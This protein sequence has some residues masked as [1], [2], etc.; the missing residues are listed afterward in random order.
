MKDETRQALIDLL[1]EKNL[2]A[3][4]EGLQNGASYSI[5]C[6]K[7]KN[8]V[9][10]GL[11]TNPTDVETLR[12]KLEK[13]F[14]D[15]RLNSPIA[16]FNRIFIKEALVALG[17]RKGIDAF[18]EY[19]QEHGIARKTPKDSYLQATLLANVWGVLDSLEK[20]KPETPRANY[21]GCVDLGGIQRV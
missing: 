9:R 16:S 3:L 2:Q 5:A 10:A 8:A 15:L 1:G 11:Q 6:F 18:H 21:Y 14:F 13:D 7:L 20:S 4:S 19:F 17:A 12:E